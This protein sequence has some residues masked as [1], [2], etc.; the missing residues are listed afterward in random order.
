MYLLPIFS[1]KDIVS[2]L[3]NEG[4]LFTE[5]DVTFRDAMRN[6]AKEPS[7]RETAGAVSN[8]LKFS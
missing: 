5:V 1:S 2:Q 8:N 6:V 3:P 7:V 4:V